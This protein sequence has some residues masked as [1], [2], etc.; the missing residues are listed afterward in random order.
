[1]VT[2]RPE[3]GGLCLH[4]RT[5]GEWERASVRKQLREREREREREKANKRD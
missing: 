5:E 2:A 1:L 3:C 4:V